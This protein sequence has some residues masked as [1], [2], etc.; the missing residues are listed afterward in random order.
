M[1]TFANPD[2]RTVT[3]GTGVP[4]R[5]TWGDIPVVDPGTPLSV[6]TGGGKHDP[7]RV[8]KSQPSVRKV[9]EFAA[10]GVASV[11]LHAFERV[12]DTD[13][14]RAAGSTLE[15]TLHLPQRHV[16]GYR[17]MH[18]LTVDLCMYDLY[19]VALIDGVLQRIPPRLLDVESDFLGAVTRIRMLTPAGKLTL[20]DFPLAFDAGWHP[21]KAHGV[22]PL[23]TLSNLLDEQ[24]RAVQWRSAQWDEGAKVSGVLKHPKSL[25]GTKRDRFVNSWRAFRT[26]GERAGGTP[27]L[28]DGME[29][30]QLEGLKPVDAQDI[31]GRQLTD[32]EVASAYHIPPELVGA[33]EGTFANI[34]AFRQMLFG[35]TLGPV[36]EGFEQ[37]FNAEIV[38]ALADQQGMYVEFNREAAMAGSFT[39]QAEVLSRSTGGPWLTRNE[40]RAR[41][42]LPALE[43]ADELVVPKNVTEGGLASP[44][45]TAPT[46]A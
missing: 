19:C 6:L 11:P 29:Y 18:D 5:T 40:A 14:R 34:A 38:P 30:Q 20:D 26:V 33:R 22:S 25:E 13:R 9:V 23:A 45:D 42:N 27:I 17:L 35:P 3:W 2:G 39:E 21:A 43:G 37:A 28:E 7:L 31:E 15:R 41:Q 44:A 12:S 46:G 16:T 4:A 1:V 8:W 10:R 36:M 24:T 32:A